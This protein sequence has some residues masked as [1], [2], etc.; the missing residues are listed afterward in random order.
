M[1]I[2]I[3]GFR[4]EGSWDGVVEHARRVTAALM[5]VLQQ[6]E[7]IEVEDYEQ[8]LEQWEEWRPRSHEDEDAY[9]E[10]LRER[11]VEQA[12][13]DEG[14]AEE[15]GVGVRE[16]LADAGRKVGDAAENLTEEGVKEAAEAVGDSAKHTSRAAETAGRRALRAFEERLYRYLMTRT[17]P[18]YFDNRLISANIE[19]VGEDEFVFEINVKDDELKEAVTEELE[20]IDTLGDKP[21]DGGEEGSSPEDGSD[22]D[23][24]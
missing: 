17:S 3:S 13:V 21:G 5:D 2:R 22:E 11:T 7:D 14:E 10:D 18:Y 16:D 19:R 4:I 15:Q 9:E 23:A 6:E 1:D 8:A 20:A 12:S 24:S